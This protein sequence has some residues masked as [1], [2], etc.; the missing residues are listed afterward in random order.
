MTPQD[1][2][3]LAR[4][5]IWISLLVGAP[6]LLAGTLVGLIIGLLQALTQIQEQTVAFVP[7]IVAMIL[8]LTF[9][10]PWLITQLVQYSDNLIASIPSR[11]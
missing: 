3:D 10:L 4:E 2:I 1:A 8:V 9:T 7:K 5:A 11:L 6:V